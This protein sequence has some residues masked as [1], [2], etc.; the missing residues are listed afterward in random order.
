MQRDGLAGQQRR[1]RCDPLAA[2]CQTVMLCRGARG[3]S[4]DPK[5]LWSGIEDS[6]L[7]HIPLRSMLAE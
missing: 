5:G 7:L 2:D 1:P 3:D 4:G 6:C